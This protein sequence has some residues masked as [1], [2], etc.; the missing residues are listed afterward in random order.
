M[1][2]SYIELKKPT[3]GIIE[4]LKN[5]KN[6]GQHIGSKWN[7]TNVLLGNRE[8]SKYIPKTK[9]LN[10]FV[11][12]SMLDEFKMVYLK[13]INGT[14]GNGVIRVEKHEEGEEVT[15]HYQM[16]IEKKNFLSLPSLYRYIIL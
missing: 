16:G 14:Y 2:E 10:Q 13:P 11:L 6:S 9:K 15:F 3:G 7:K 5:I 4:K 1:N 8:I 12:K